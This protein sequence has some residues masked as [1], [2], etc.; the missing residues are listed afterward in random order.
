MAENKIE[1]IVNGNK[2]IAKK[3]GK[4]G[5]V[6]CSPE[7]DFD[8]FVGAKLALER[9]EEEYKPYSW[10]K[11]GIRYYYPSVSEDILYGCFTYSN[12]YID[13][14]IISLGLV[15]KT[16]E[17]AVEAAKK[18]LAALNQANEC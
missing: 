8:I 15:F 2:V 6:K 12:D 14:I 11:K 18:M 13:K 4:V 3:D 7:D 9:L 17:E 1:I 5:V 10:L 16:E